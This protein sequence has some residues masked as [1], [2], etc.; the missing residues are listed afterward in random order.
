M[1]LVVNHLSHRDLTACLILYI[2]PFN[3]LFISLGCRVVHKNKD[4][5]IMN[6]TTAQSLTEGRANNTTSTIIKTVFKS[7]ANCSK[8][9]GE[10]R[11]QSRDATP[12]NYS[13]TVFK[14]SLLF[15]NVLSCWWK[16]LTLQSTRH[17]DRLRTRSG[18]TG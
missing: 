1:H 9:V 11:E 18:R 14:H 12:V 8:A 6:A 4:H 13:S 10:Y 7:L 16:F 15:F 17:W 2:C 5:R 3:T